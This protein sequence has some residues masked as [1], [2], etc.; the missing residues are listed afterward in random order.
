MKFRF[1]MAVERKMAAR[2]LIAMMRLRLCSV[3]MLAGLRIRRRPAVSFFCFT[4]TELVIVIAILFILITLLLLSVGWVRETAS[5]NGCRSSI[6]QYSQVVHM[7]AADNYGYFLTSSANTL[8]QQHEFRSFW[9]LARVYLPTAV[10][11]R[12]WDT[13]GSSVFS[14]RADGI[15]L[16]LLCASAVRSFEEYR[17]LLQ[18][19]E[20]FDARPTRR[21][22]YST[23][24]I[25]SDSHPAA[26]EAGGK[27]KVD[28]LPKPSWYFFMH[29]TGFNDMT[30]DRDY[31]FWVLRKQLDGTM[32]WGHGLFYN[33]GFLD[34]H[35]TGYKRKRRDLSWQSN[36]TR[37]FVP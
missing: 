9:E 17:T 22:V 15:P 6:R 23:A 8:S 10:T 1:P 13:Y 27:Q 21:G 35:A 29:E 37:V 7:Y 26:R 4:I 5:R 20:L 12:Y 34:G 2:R 19:E 36:Y 33:V 3:L 14:D 31:P 24:M 18:I 28:R 25:N 30:D 11:T 32:H 16:S